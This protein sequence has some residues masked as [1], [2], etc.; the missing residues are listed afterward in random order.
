MNG[1]PYDFQ[2][3][4]TQEKVFDI[5]AL[6]TITDIGLSF[7]QTPHSFVD[8]SGNEIPHL[9]NFDNEILP[10]LFLKNVYITLGYDVS[11]FDKEMIQIHTLGSNSYSSQDLNPKQVQLRWIHKQNDGSFKSITI[12]D[13]LDCEIRWYRYELGHA[14]AD[15]YSDVYWKYLSTQK[16]EEG[17]WAY[18]IFDEDLV[19]A[20][21]EPDFFYT[22]LAPNQRQATERIK[23]ILIYQGEV[24]RSNTLTF[25][26]SEEVSNTEILDSLYGLNIYCEDGT[27]GNYRMY[28]LGGGLLDNAQGYIPRK[29]KPMFKSIEDEGM[30][31]EITE[32]DSITWIIPKVNTMIRVEEADW[33][34]GLD[35]STD[36]NYII[37]RTSGKDGVLAAN[38]QTYY[39]K[40]YYNQNY[41][42]NTIQCRIIKDGNVLVAAKELTFGPAGSSGTDC[43]FILDFDN[44]VT[45]MTD[46]EE[47]KKTAIKVT[48]RLYDYENN[49]VNISD[50]TIE[51]GWKTDNHLFEIVNQNTNYSSACELIFKNGIT[52]N[53]SSNYSILQAKLTDWGDYDLIAYLP[54]P[55]RSDN[56]YVMISG[57][58]Q[59]IYN[60]DGCLTDYFKNP[61][62]IWGNKDKP[63]LDEE[64]NETGETVQVFGQI[65]GVKWSIENYITGETQK[66]YTPEII[67]Q[68]D[69]EDKTKIIAQY[70]QPLSFYVEDACENVSVIA[71]LDGKVIWRQPILIMLNRYPAAMLNNWDGKLEIDTENGNIMAPRLV[72][73][74]KDENDNSFSGI[75]L[76]EFETISTETEK[77]LKSTGLFG[78]DHGE[79][80][81]GF[82]QDGT[83]FIGKS[84]L[85][86][87]EF[88]GEN[89]IIKSSG[90]EN[91]KGMKIDLKE[92]Q[93]DAQV[94]SKSI[95]KLFQNSP[96]LQ[97]QNA[98]GNTLMSIGNNEYYLQ[99]ANYTEGGTT[100]AYFDLASGRLTL[101]DGTFRGQVEINYTG[102]RVS[103]YTTPLNDILDDLDYAAAEAADAAAE[104]QESIDML[105]KFFNIY[106][107][108]LNQDVLDM[109]TAKYERD[110]TLEGVCPQRAHVQLGNG[111]IIEAE[112]TER[113]LNR[114]GA[115]N[116]QGQNDYTGEIII[117]GN[118]LSFY[119][120]T[121]CKFYKN[122]TEVDM[123]SGGTATAVFG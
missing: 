100:G 46:T 19:E 16:K 122:G 74:K 18:E 23:A 117:A 47:G 120:N 33:A 2:S 63:V 44:G 111:I 21:I 96:Y 77:A 116:V 45:A 22:W 50:K 26:N 68:T 40:N 64:E 101:R 95:F 89:G 15:A 78:F 114:Y 9:D 60:S 70:L 99:S 90:Y 58:T 43:T 62:Q 20:K 92:N 112:A 69:K 72:A 105:K 1:N 103:S 29:L 48:A 35:N 24:Y 7:Y 52:I 25:T 75:M 11:D 61:F 39:I 49:E 98:K 86:R 118:A 27:Y 3:F 37:T 13:D 34:G 113:E 8:S 110:E 104:A 76:G 82:R 36:E 84:G 28:K 42:N 83:A 85:G 51:W 123:G 53:K 81:Y 109:N 73:G 30:A 56:K 38:T 80:S 31:T 107:G 87:I 5:S 55:L 41:S 32:F 94:N 67:D 4:Y 121:S 57:T 59:V 66:G 10:N 102:K 97:I 65:D 17:K 71:E 54:I 88:S 91:G 79:M 115:I 106:R 108:N 14:S 12:S 119:Y 6:G 93:I